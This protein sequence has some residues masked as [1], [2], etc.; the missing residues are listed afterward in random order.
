[1]VVA[2]ANPGS[3]AVRLFVHMRAFADLAELYL[4]INKLLH[5]TQAQPGARSNVHMVT[6]QD[7]IKSRYMGKE[8]DAAA[9]ACRDPLQG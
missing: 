9:Q 1:V 2:T 6:E 7:D 8:G 5:Q 4:D 3:L